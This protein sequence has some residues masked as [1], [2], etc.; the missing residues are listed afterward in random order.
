MQMFGERLLAAGLDSGNTLMYPLDD[1]ATNTSVVSK[2]HKKQ[3]GRMLF[4]LFMVCFGSSA[5][6]K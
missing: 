2:Q 1:P 6:W 5:R 4:L 3:G